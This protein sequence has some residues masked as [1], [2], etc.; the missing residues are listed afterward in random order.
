MDAI[1]PWLSERWQDI[2][3][4]ASVFLA[5]VIV[6]LWM[7]RWASARLD[8]WV[9]RTRWPGDDILFRALRGPSLLWLL[10]VSVYL[11]VQVS[12]LPAEW[13]VSLG[14]GLWTVA[15]ASLAVSAIALSSGL[16][17][18]YGERLHL[19]GQATSGASVA[20]AGIILLLALLTVLDLW[21]A[22]MAP[23]LVVL[24]LVVLVAGVALR[25]VLP[26]FLASFQVRASGQ[27]K[28][29]DFIKLDSGEEGYVEDIGWGSTRIRAPDQSVVAVPNSKL[30]RTTVIN[31]G[32]PLK[33]A[34]EPFHFY[35]RTHLKEL[36]GLR[37]RD[38]SELAQ[39]LRQ[40]P[41]SVV[42]YHTHHFLEEHHYLTPEPPNDF[43]MWVTDVLGD[44]VLGERLAAVDTFQFS[45]LTAL[46]DRLVGI[47]EEHLAGVGDHGQAEEAR[48]SHR[49]VPDGRE[50]HF[51][52]S[53]SFV[54]PTPYVAHDLRELVQVLRKLSLGSLYFH[55]FESR[56]RLGRSRNDFSI[57]MAES[58]GEEQLAE[59][60]A[61]LDPYQ[62][63]LEELRSQLIRLV[64]KRV[65]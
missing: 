61:H 16:I 8:H 2:L 39:V 43:A 37:A 11:G 52:K 47:I 29:D 63:T 23:L 1:G 59:E 12:A 34:A 60:I 3:V 30:V 18:L 14:R 42:Y 24:A 33:V 45:T 55:V 9:R 13:R 58:L 31:Y 32:R 50:F 65:K 36:T 64:E 56:M 21:G 26:N 49:Q 28:V 19:P 53:M 15:I 41:E 5:S 51:I 27:F 20:T 25:D 44:D 48:A 7:R 6:L 35:S 22:P 40:V 38:L 46:R 57:W 10:V 4:P 17:R 62:Y 54:M